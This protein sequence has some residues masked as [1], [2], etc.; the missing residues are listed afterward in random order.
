M[1]R[2]LP[3]LILTISIAIFTTPGNAE[4]DLAGY[5]QHE[6]EPVWIKCSPKQDRAWCFATT[7]GRIASA[8]WW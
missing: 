6:S 5:W 4:V 2:L 8:F 1:I 7:I 3:G